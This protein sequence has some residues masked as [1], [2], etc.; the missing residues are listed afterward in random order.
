MSEGLNKVILVGNLG[1]DPELKL[2]QG[3]AAILRLRLATTESWLD[4]QGSR[5]ERTDWHTVIVHGKRGEALNKILRK[6][7][8]LWVEGRLETRSWEAQD[9][10]KRSATEVVARDVGFTGGPRRGQQQQA[11]PQ[12]QLE[13]PFDGNGDDDDVPF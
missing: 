13:T 8:G 1:M 11:A 12:Q 5:K 6:G 7:D 9:G 4:K 2:M 10:S 3:G